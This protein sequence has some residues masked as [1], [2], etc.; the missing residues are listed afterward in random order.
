MFIRTE[1]FQTFIRL[2]PVVTFILALQAVLWLF[3]SLPVHSVVLWRDAVTGYNLGVANGEWWRLITPVLLHV[4]FTHLLFNSM[5]IFLFAP[6]LER[7]LGKA[8]FLLVYA[9]SGI[10]G[11]I[12]T[13]VTEP[14]DYVHVGASGAIFGLFGV[15]LF[16]V[17]FHK[18]LIGQEHSK[19]ILTL[20]A[21]AVLMSFI[22]SNINMM[23]HLF[24]LCGGFLLSFL[25]VQKKERRY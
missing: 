25:C 18:E 21:F 19:M 17:L 16:M 3:F 6:A 12:G 7:M 2:Y 13:Y 23:A 8:R 24:G 1:N 10:I 9:G 4:G 14:L 5:S 11:N 15:Y 22:N 20:L